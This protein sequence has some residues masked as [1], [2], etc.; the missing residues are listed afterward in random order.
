[1]DAVGGRVPQAR[2]EQG[3]AVGPD[4]TDDEREA[5]GEPQVH[6]TRESPERPF[7]CASR[8]LASAGT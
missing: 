7:A 1:M 3:L 8:H 6:I 2:R 4:A 5:V